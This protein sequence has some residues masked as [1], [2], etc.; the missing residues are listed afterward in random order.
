[1]LLSSAVA[2]GSEMLPI[3]VAVDMSASNGWLLWYCLAVVA[4]G[5]F[6]KAVDEP[7]TGIALLGKGVKAKRPPRPPAL[8]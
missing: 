7:S 2:E 6:V 3:D 5:P 4:D 8:A 1:M